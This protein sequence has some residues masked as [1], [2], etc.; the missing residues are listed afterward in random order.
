[1]D[2][3]VLANKLTWFFYGSEFSNARMVWV[4]K[5]GRLA[6]NYE[7]S[8]SNSRL[9]AVG[10]RGD[11]YM[12]GPTGRR[13]QCVAAIPGSTA[14]LWSV[15]LDDGSRPIG[16]ALVPGTLYVSTFDALSEEGV[17]YALSEN[18]GAVQP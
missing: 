8:L 9:I 4:D 18:T 15:D 3:G 14:P 1:M 12:C 16:G 10:A 2:S 7:L 11:A 5:D 6:G 17:L 13:V